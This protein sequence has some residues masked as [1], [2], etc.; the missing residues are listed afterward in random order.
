[1][2][3]VSGRRGW[4]EWGRKAREEEEMEETNEKYRAGLIGPDRVAWGGIEGTLPRSEE[5]R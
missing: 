1:M 4:E 3:A 5:I 2:E